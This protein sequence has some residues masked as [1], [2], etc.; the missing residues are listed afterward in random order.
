[1]PTGSIKRKY[2]TRA[3]V[4]RNTGT[5]FKG[6]RR[7]FARKMYTRPPKLMLRLRRIENTIETK[8]A[9]SS[10]FAQNL[11]HNNVSTVLNLFQ[12]G[13]GTADPMGNGGNRI[14]DKITIKGLSIVGFIQN[15]LQRSKVFYRVMIIKGAKGEPFDRA[16]LFKNNSGNKM[17]DQINT[18]RYTVLAQKV[19]T[20]SASNASATFVNNPATQGQPTYGPTDLQYGGLG[21]K[22]IRMWIPGSKIC[23]GGNLQYENGSATQPKFFDYRVIVMAYDWNATPQDINNVGLINE[24]YQKVYFKD[25]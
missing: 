1:M 16:T 5:M 11:A 25:A 14:G 15:Q 3:R 23:R 19:F 13:Q 10:V 20:I 21:T 24:M 4:A 6:A 8:E 9:C 2:S 18:E 12:F 22:I 17:I 7:L